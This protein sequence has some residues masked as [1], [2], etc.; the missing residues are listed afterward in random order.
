MGWPV[1]V[2]LN[3]RLR[4]EHR[5]SCE[6]FLQECSMSGLWAARVTGGG[7]ELS[8]EGETLSCD[9]EIDIAS[10]PDAAV[11]A[12]VEALETSG[13]GAPTGSA[14]VLGDRQPVRFG[15]SEGVALYLN[16]TALPREVYANSDPNDLI[17][18]LADSL[19]G[20]GSAA[21][22]WE[23]PRETAIYMNGRS[24]ERMTE[25]I[26]GVIDT[27]P[28]TQRSSLVAITESTAS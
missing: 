6:D 16:G 28:L 1:I 3:A 24:A 14:V 27:Q 18:L 9:I 26:A 4:V 25:L 5:R 20:H 2:H 11:A 17:G 10:D 7:S 22:F 21:S 23:G 12:I 8:P 15:R 13:F 19:G